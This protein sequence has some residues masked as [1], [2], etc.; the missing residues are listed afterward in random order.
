MKIYPPSHT[1]FY[2]NVVIKYKR[3]DAFAAISSPYFES[4]PSNIEDLQKF[5]GFI[6]DKI[7]PKQ[8]PAQCP[9][10]A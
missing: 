7:I 9:C 1:Q 10:L 3:Q 6:R 4:F 5:E 2:K 8:S